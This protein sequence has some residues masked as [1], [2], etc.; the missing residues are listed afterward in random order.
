M[1]VGGGL[2]GEMG[3]GEH[4]SHV[5]YGGYGMAGNPVGHHLGFDESL[6]QQDGHGLVDREGERVSVKSEPRWE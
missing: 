1:G 2:Y 3:R 5:G 4:H 6:W